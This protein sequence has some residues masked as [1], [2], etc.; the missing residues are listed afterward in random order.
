L[1]PKTVVGP[2]HIVAAFLCR[3]CVG[4]LSNNLLM[5]NSQ[6]TGCLANT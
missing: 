4:A 2:E 1:E 6:S 3:K 5:S